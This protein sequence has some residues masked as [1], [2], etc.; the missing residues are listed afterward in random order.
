MAVMVAYEK[1]MGLI[2]NF[3]SV[4]ILDPTWN[5][6]DG[7]LVVCNEEGSLPKYSKDEEFKNGKSGKTLLNLAS[8]LSKFLVDS[9][10][11]IKMQEVNKS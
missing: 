1:Q 3:P 7:G 6:G 4:G 11:L 2:L 9:S 8:L 10:G 5:F